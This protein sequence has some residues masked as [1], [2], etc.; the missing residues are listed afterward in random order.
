MET[1][2]KSLKY[3]YD[4]KTIIL[5]ITILYLIP[6]EIW[7][8]PYIN[9]DSSWQI[10]LNL[11]IKQ[12]LIW[13]KDIVFTYGPLGYLS[14]GLPV[15]TS[16][17]LIGLFTLYISASGGFFL[18]I[19]F[20]AVKQKYEL[21]FITVFL[22]LNGHFL[23][24]RD[25]IALYFYTL[26][27][28]LYY[29][30]SGK[31]YSIIPVII[32]CILAFFIKVNTGIILI[33]IFV[34]FLIYIY[35]TLLISFKEFLAYLIT[36]TLLIFLL[37]YHLQVD[38]LFYIKNSLPIIDGYNDAMALFPEVD[39]LFFAVLIIVSL[40]LP[41]FIYSKL[42]LNSKQAIFL[43]LNVALLLFI[44]FK[45]SFVR[46]DSYHYYLFFASSP[47]LVFLIY[48]FN[49]IYKIKRHVYYTLIITCLLSIAGF[50]GQRIK[51]LASNLGYISISKYMGHYI[52]F[53]SKK[54]DDSNE[55]KSREL[56]ERVKDTIG[57]KTADVLGY[58]LSYLYFN[59]LTYNPR[60]VIQSYS[61]YGP[62][63]IQMNVNKY[64]SKTAPDFVLYHPGSIDGRHPFWDES[65]IYLSLFKNYIIVDTF[66]SINLSFDEFGTHNK[67][68][69]KLFLFKKNNKKKNITKTVLKDTLIH[70]NTEINIP[71]SNNIIYM[72]MESELTP[73]GKMQRILFQPSLVHMKLHYTDGD[74]THCRL[75]LPVMK[76]GVPINKKVID[77]DAA[78]LFFSTKGT[79]NIP[80]TSFTLSG[81]PKL[82][83]DSFRVKFI[84]YQIQD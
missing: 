47:F 61:A 30:N 50:K 69:N 20:K 60:P 36:F 23:F 44:I 29:L 3:K 54:L 26:F 1:Y 79:G 10:A 55:T 13:G 25:S 14:T 62:E 82:I 32:N 34:T 58:E 81:N 74:S 15:Y 63:L 11:A 41:F 45:Q 56:P 24:L 78:Y 70:F 18:Y 27:F 31:W 77:P 76:A 46:G 35:R 17:F 64:E 73:T 42:M 75:V 51:I 48:F 83:K 80:A 66:S 5:I 2:I 8:T 39:A 57:D 22:L 28:M 37:S 21:I 40:L 12:Q 19:L 65:P 59:N 38:L 33:F 4:F 43:F 68:P 9:L 71:Y 53:P 52:F 7:N 67:V 84:E 6:K 72:E 49:D 16:A